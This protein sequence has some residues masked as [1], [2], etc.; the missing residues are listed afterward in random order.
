[1]NAYIANVFA[2]HVQIVIETRNFSIYNVAFYLLSLSMMFV[3]INLNDGFITSTYVGYYYKNQW[4]VLMASP[5]FYLC[6]LI[7]VFVIVLPNIINR[8]LESAIFYPE[9][10]KIKSD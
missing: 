10:S 7:Q 8:C 4:S 2:H 6:L 1:M 5:L 9:F 3:S